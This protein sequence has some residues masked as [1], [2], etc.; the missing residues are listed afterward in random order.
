LSER[1]ASYLRLGDK[2]AQSQNYDDAEWAYW[3]AAEL[4][5]KRVRAYEGLGEVYAAQERYGEATR[6][7]DE[8]LKLKPKK[9]ELHFQ[10]GVLFQKMGD[11]AAAR[12]K[13]Q[14]LRDMK[15]K[16]LA[17]QLEFWLSRPPRQSTKR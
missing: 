11:A 15:K 9:A 6:A 7:Y 10:L 13:L 5:P 12:E 8:A 4:D 3:R 17:A 16:E 14:L 1:V 2:A